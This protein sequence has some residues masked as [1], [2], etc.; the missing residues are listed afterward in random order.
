MDVEIGA[1]GYHNHEADYPHYATCFVCEKL[2]EGMPIGS[3][4]TP[5][6]FICSQQCESRRMSKLI[7]LIGIPKRYRNCSFDTFNA[8]V[9]TASAYNTCVGW[10][11]E[12]PSIFL[13]GPPGTGKTHLMTAIGR[14]ALENGAKPNTI[15]FWSVLDLMTHIK[16]GWNNHEDDP[17]RDVRNVQLL[18]LDDLGMEIVRDWVFQELL[19]L[20][21][22][23]YNE[24]LATCLSSNLTEEQLLDRYGPAVFSRLTEMCI[25][26]NMSKVSDYRLQIVTEQKETIDL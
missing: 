4:L 12:P 10:D 16:R 1:N 23:R 24:E 11:K 19:N 9:S 13:I 5:H 21:C 7:G 6:G 25:P 26:I 20:F 2:I 15:H 18:L 8:N 14:K 22:H 17:L 3:Q